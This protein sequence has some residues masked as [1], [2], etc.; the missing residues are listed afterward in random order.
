MYNN[1]III[2]YDCRT[3][4]YRVGKHLFEEHASLLLTKAKKNTA[5]TDHNYTYMKPFTFL[6]IIPHTSLNLYFMYIHLNMDLRY[7]CI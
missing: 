6:S 5:K 3:S 1:I 7:R 4:C 2:Y